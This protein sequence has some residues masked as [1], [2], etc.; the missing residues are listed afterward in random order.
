MKVVRVDLD[1]YPVITQ[2][3]GENVAA[4]ISVCEEDVIMQRLGA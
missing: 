3:G 1:F 2:Y 4:Q